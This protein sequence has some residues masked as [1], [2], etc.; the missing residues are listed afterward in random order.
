MYK[1]SFLS[2]ADIKEEWN[3]NVTPPSV[4][5]TCPG[6][7]LFIQQSIHVIANS[8]LYLSVEDVE[9]VVE[10]A[11]NK[12]D[13][14]GGKT[15]GRNRQANRLSRSFQRIVTPGGLT[16]ED[17]LY[18]WRNNFHFIAL[19]SYEIACVM[20]TYS[21]YCYMYWRWIMHS[22]STV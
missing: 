5:K 6:I 13:I 17:F 15:C 2:G 4:F 12:W 8:M 1:W 19:F 20:N 3:C 21:L 11:P 14:L 16:N 9:L 7:I 18:V 10:Y 22:Y